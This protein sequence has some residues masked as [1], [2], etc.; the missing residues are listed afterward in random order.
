MNRRRLLA[1]TVAA[2]AAARADSALLPDRPAPRLGLTIA[3]YMQRW[4]PGFRQGWEDALDVLEHVHRLG[5]ECLQIG[6][7]GW[8]QDFAGRVRAR[9][10]ALGITLEGQISLPKDPG[11]AERFEADVRAARE[12]GAL[13]LRTV[14][15]GGRRYESF[16]TPGDWERFG[17]ESRASLEL[18]EPILAKHGVKLAVENHKDWRLDEFLALLRHLDSPWIG[19]TF[20]FGNNLALLESPADLIAP[21]APHLLTVHFKDM[22]LAPSPDG[23]LLSEVPVGTG[24]LDLRGMVD[25]CLAANPGI[26]FNLEMITRDPLPVPVLRD[27]YWATLPAVPARDL[28]RTLRLAAS[29]VA[30]SLPRISGLPPAEVVA[31]EEANVVASIRAARERLGFS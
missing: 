23:F 15:L 30:A 31:L 26:R 1:S 21:L 5:L 19:V 8:S 27:A 17:A 7:G 16:A 20:D 12:A 25:A 11:S 29:G 10:E 28:A 6:V 18:A 3:S 9:R 4:R 22:A 2:A 24:I 13:V 14:C